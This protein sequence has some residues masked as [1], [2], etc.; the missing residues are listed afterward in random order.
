MPATFAR[1]IIPKSKTCPKNS[2]K[3]VNTS[4]FILDLD[5]RSDSIQNLKL[6]KPFGRIDA[7]HFL[8]NINFRTDRISKRDQKFLVSLDDE[9]F[10]STSSH[11][12]PDYTQRRTCD[13]F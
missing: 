9:K 2:G 8:F 13:R 4:I 11:Q 3:I 5:L 10:R 6:Q 1:R 12:F 7:D